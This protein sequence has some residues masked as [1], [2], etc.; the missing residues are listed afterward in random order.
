MACALKQGLP[1]KKTAERT[2]WRVSACG[3]ALRRKLLQPIL[4]QMDRFWRALVF[5]LPL[6]LASNMGLSPT[7][8]APCGSAAGRCG[9]GRR[10]GQAARRGRGARRWPAD[11]GRSRPMAAAAPGRRRQARER[12]RSG[13]AERGA[14]NRS[15]AVWGVRVGQNEKKGPRQSLGPEMG[16]RTALRKRRVR[17]RPPDRRTTSVRRRN[18]RDRR[19]RRSGAFPGPR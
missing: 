14:G 19:R 12:R 18:R 9:Q 2:D 1:G 6:P 13:G 4:L 3:G 15:E 7:S 8:P 5:G 17:R 11:A 10:L 16:Y